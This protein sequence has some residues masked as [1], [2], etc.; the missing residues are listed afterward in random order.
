MLH[1]LINIPHSKHFILAV[2]GGVD[3]LAIA[4]FYV[5]GNKDFHLAYF[6]HNT[7]LADKMQD[8]CLAFAEAH[9]VPIHCGRLQAEKP[10]DQS[11]EEF[12]RN[13]RYAWLLS[14]HPTASIITCHHLNDVA[15]TWIFSSLHGN[16][17]LILSQNGDRIVRPFL[18]NT[19][20]Q[21]I[22]WAVQHNVKWVEDESNAD[23]HFP[24]NRIRHKI[25]PECLQVNPGLLTVLKK[26]I[27]ERERERFDFDERAKE[28]Q[29]SRDKDADDLMSGKKDNKSLAEENGAFSFPIDRI[30]IKTYR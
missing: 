26:K 10:T 11:P 19:K 28:K 15:E 24:R 8:A 6:H 21:L 1:Q 13:E 20:Q 18:T 29:A 14:L 2:S 17:K 30:K 22:D 4:D 16:P 12:W 9:G 23:V 3:S 7:K 25:L 5:R 27:I